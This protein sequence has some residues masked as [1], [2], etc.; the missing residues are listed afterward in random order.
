MVIL[1]VVWALTA[2]GL[3]A[4]A[5]RLPTRSALLWWAGFALVACLAG[6]FAISRQP[7]GQST[8]WGRLGSAF[9]HWGFRAGR[10]Q[11]PAALG[12]SLVVWLLIG[13]TAI[14]AWGARTEPR[15]ALIILAWAANLAVLFYMVGVMLANPGTSRQLVTV[16]G[17]VLGLT[18]VS[19]AFW[20]ARTP[21][22][23]RLALLIAG[24]P[25][26]LVGV[27]YGLFLLIVVVFGRNAR[28]N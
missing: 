9:V 28:W 5:T 20:T 2:A 22:A 21:G 12:I 8:I 11:L 19:A 4:I 10:G 26:L 7:I 6:A 23:Q 1:L 25:V 17:V 27:V 16:S 14:L 15:Q 3:A 24:G 13:S 18:V